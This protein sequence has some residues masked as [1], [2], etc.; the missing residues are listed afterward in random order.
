MKKKSK[1]SHEEYQVIF[2]KYYKE[3]RNYSQIGKHLGRDRSTI[4]RV[5]KYKIH[6]NPSYWFSLTTFEKASFAQKVTKE[7]LSKRRARMRLKTPRIRRVVM[8]ILR[9]WHWSPEKI[10]DFLKEHGLLISAKAIYNFTK[11][12]ASV[13]RAYLRLRG[14]ARRQRVARPRSIF[15][16]GVPAKR[17][18]HE[19]L[20]LYG[21]GH[22]E[23]D[24]IVSKRGGKG[25][26][27][28][29]R[30]FGSKRAFYFLIPDLKASTV[31]RILLPF[32][33][34]LPEKIRKTITSDN[35]SEFAELYKLEKVMP[36]FK[37][38]YCDPYKAWQRGSV[39]NANGELRW[40]Y[41]KG[42]DFS[43]VCAVELRKAEYKI[44]GKP[45]KVNRGRSSIAVFKKL[46]KKAAA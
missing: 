18:I 2:E 26:V 22:W 21:Y 36:S 30:E 25:G 24:T 44:N 16:T 31:I 15:K 38:F 6:P 33:Q 7:N 17:S 46:L 34:R 39:E 32:F 37:V 43:K 11:K 5:F 29:I 19:R 28:T 13:L 40:Y 27:L 20:K 4:S 8:F 10:S 42:T 3:S 12:E 41:P 9:K 35:G 45:M 1:L 14:K 23:I